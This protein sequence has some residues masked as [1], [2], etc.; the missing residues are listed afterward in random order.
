MEELEFT[1]NTYTSVFRS[2]IALLTRPRTRAIIV[3][4]AHSFPPTFFL[5]LCVLAFHT[6]FIFSLA[7]SY[8]SGFR[9]LS[10][11]VAFARFTASATFT[12]V[13]LSFLLFQFSNARKQASKQARTHAH[14]H[15]RTHAG[16]RRFARER[17]GRAPFFRSA[18]RR[19]SPGV[20]VAVRN[21]SFFFSFFAAF[22]HSLIV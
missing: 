10:R 17:V 7:R 8:S 14:T 12:L 4:S 16:R 18:E 21:V 1:R 15:T 2:K 3:P 19:W 13:S 5:P 22:P 11:G 9:F 6:L 20:L